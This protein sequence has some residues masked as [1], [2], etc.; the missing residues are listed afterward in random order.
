M[1]VRDALLALLDEESK[2]GY[3]LKAEFEAATGEAWSL[4]IGQVYST[5]QRLERDGL[6][7]SLGPD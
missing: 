1:T 6:V 4:N 5:L 2:Y 7:E 3:Q